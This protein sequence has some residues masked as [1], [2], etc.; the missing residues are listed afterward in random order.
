MP[1]PQRTS[2]E[3]I[4]AAGREALE[5]GGPD[6]VTMNAVAARVGV[7]AP[8]LYKRVRDRDELLGMIAAATL[9]DLRERMQGQESLAGLARTYRSFAH[10]HPEGFRLIQTRT[11]SAQ[12]LARASEPVLAAA[13][14]AVGDAEA[15]EAA[16]FMTAWLTGFI[17]MELA[18]AFRLGG[19]LDKAFDYGIER[20]AA[21]LSD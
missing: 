11:A 20:V 21:A 19:D 16:R 17:T 6:R 1:S 8:S 5:E 15:L 3:A 7:R 10:G 2:L 18:G 14:N 12:D 13:R 4:V 9:D